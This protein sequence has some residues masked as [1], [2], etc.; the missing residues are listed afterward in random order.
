MATKKH[1]SVD[2][3]WFAVGYYHA[4]VSKKEPPSDDVVVYLSESIG[5]NIMHSY[6][7]GFSHGEK[8]LFVGIN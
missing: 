8:D 3:Y 1:V 6:M 7:S 4:M 2:R 5:V